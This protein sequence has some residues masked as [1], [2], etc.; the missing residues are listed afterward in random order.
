MAPPTILIIEDN[1]MNLELA[2]TLL[3]TTGFAVVP[4]RTAEEG[5]RLA[6]QHLPD[7]ILMDFSLPGMDGLT[8]TRELKANPLTCHLAVIGLSANAMKGDEETAL[9]AGCNGY[10]TKPIDTRTF[11]S[12]IKNFIS[13]VETNHK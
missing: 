8:A 6:E 1:E 10:L 13:T 2:I 4:A 5:L 11:A 3:E 12:I 7:L 9:E